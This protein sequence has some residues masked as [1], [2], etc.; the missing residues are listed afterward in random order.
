[1]SDDRVALTRQVKEA[2]DIVAVV[3]SYLAVHPAGGVYKAVCPFH[4]DT[5]PSLQVDPKW[6]NFRCWSCGKKGDVFTFVSEFEKV[7]FR[8]ARE[9]LARRAGINLEGSPAENV[10]RG[11]LLDAM[12]WAEKAVP[13]VPARQTRSASGARLYLGERK[14][15]GPTVR[16]FGLGFAPAAGD[17]LVRAANAARL[18]M[19]LLEEVGLVA[20]RKEGNGVLR[21]VPR[22]GHVP[23]PR[24][25]RADGRLRRPNSAGFALRRPRA[26]STT[27]RRTRRC[28]PRANC[29]TA[30]TW[31]GTPG[32]T[33]GYLAVVEGYT[34][35]MMAHQH[36][37]AHV[38]ATMGTALNE[39]HVRQLRRFVPKVVLVFDADAGGTTGR[40]PGP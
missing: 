32:A 31:P 2:S 20:D 33:E 3:G 6:Q 17:W 36:G 10:R 25:A 8:E 9:L 28:S 40:G 12:R 30:W 24:R 14:L 22:P 18:D 11:K 39:P 23:D 7:T 15:A 21:P 5:R 26:R 16:S 19:G 4:N 35:V 38:V 34:D 13:G 27:T 37:V 1:M 29:S